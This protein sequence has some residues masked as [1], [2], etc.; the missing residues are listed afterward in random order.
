MLAVRSPAAEAETMLCIAH[1]GI[2][3]TMLA[4]LAARCCTVDPLLRSAVC[5][6]TSWA[7][8]AMRLAALCLREDA[9]HAPMARSSAAHPELEKGLVLGHVAVLADDTR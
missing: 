5:C 2:T 7:S 8:H 3:S 1:L 9:V 6:A 4:S